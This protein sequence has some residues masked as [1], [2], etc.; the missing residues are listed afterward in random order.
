MASR[1]IPQSSSRYVF[2]VCVTDGKETATVTNSSIHMYLCYGAENMKSNFPPLVLHF[3]SSYGN[4]S[5][6]SHKGVGKR[7]VITLTVPRAV[8][9]R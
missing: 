8:G 2:N 1:S 7:T 3:R 6:N 5:C 4:T 9:N